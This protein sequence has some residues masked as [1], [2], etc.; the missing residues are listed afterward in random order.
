MFTY[1]QNSCVLREIRVGEHDG[2][3][4]FLTGNRNIHH[5]I[6][7]I[8]VTRCA[9]SSHRLVNS[10]LRQIPCS[11]ERISCFRY[12]DWLNRRFTYIR[13]I[14]GACICCQIVKE[15]SR[16]QSCLV[17]QC[18]VV[19]TNGTTLRGLSLDGSSTA[20]AGA[21]RR[22]SIKKTCHSTLSG[23]KVNP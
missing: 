13:Y 15:S 7:L 20:T 8:E 17:L 2:D 12:N 22:S 4:R 19:L 14:S 10:A 6:N 1:R 11:T 3:V 16:K 5:D 9:Q 23:K 18:L 21:H